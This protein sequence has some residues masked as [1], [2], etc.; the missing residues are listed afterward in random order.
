M[1]H[2]E[3][4]DHLHDLVNHE[5]I[6]RA[7]L[8]E[9]LSLD[10]MKA[11]MTA[12]AD[13]QDSFPVI[14]VTGTNGKGSTVRMI[15]SILATM[16]LR[17]GS[18]TSPHLQ[19]I[20]ER[21]RVGGES[22]ADED[23]AAGITGVAAAVDAMAGPNLSWFETMTAAAF[24]HFANEAV[25][26]A[27]LEVGM[28]GRFDATNVAHARISV[29][30]NVGFDH[31]DGVG[32]WRSDI[33]REKAGIVEPGST[34]VLGETDPDLAAIFCDESPAVVLERGIDFALLD[35]S[36]AV[37]GRLMDLR[38]PR[39]RYEEVFVGLHGRHQ[40]DNA[41]LAVTTVEEFFD[42]QLPPDV[43][44]EALATVSVP[45]R[46]EIVGRSPLVMLDVAH[47][48]PGAEALSLAVEGAFGDSRR[49]IVLGLLDGRDAET[50][51]E[52]LCV[53]DA[54]LVIACSAP[55]RRGLPA[56][57]VADGVRSAGGSAEVI[58]PVGDAVDRALSLAGSQ[59]MVLVVGS[60]TVVGE[61]R[62]HLGVN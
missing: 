17:V 3:A 38:T 11:V 40:C 13:P 6:P 56:R 19:S 18:Y 57:L 55:S 25:D 21:I 4:L 29:V 46:M 20:N 43:V 5:V 8:I 2:R 60:H 1:D 10:A 48:P 42:H 50:I 23:L 31:T 16:G 15:E 47:N 59:D 39:A 53:A 44:A 49:I 62:G 9:G 7:G 35:D 37:G 58:E 30:T 26:V 33:A 34:L 12:L 54:D 51:S 36:L 52:A 27:L 22:V 61:A 45:G 28:L 24:T 14:H 41:A 32:D